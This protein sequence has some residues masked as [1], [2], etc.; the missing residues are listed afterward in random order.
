MHFEA[1]EVAATR[2]WNEASIVEK[3]QAVSMKIDGCALNVLVEA[4]LVAAI[5]EQFCGA[6]RSGWFRGLNNSGIDRLDNRDPFRQSGCH[7]SIKCRTTLHC[8]HPAEHS[9][10]DGRAPCHHQQEQY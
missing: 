1:R 7:E 6:C 3:I 4:Q 9:N 5:P 10:P 2:R 8:S